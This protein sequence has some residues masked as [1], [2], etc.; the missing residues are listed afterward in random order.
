M[1]SL[2]LQLSDA[3]TAMFIV[4]TPHLNVIQKWTR[5]KLLD[6]LVIDVAYNTMVKH[7]ARRPWEDWNLAKGGLCE[8]HHVYNI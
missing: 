7:L 5:R 4:S 8:S 3:D 6:S 2:G 1:P